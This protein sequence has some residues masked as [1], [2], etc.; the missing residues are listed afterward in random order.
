MQKILTTFKISISQITAERETVFI[1]SISSALSLISIIAVWLASDISTLGGY[2]RSELIT[3]YIVVF[4]LEQFIGWYV[5]WEIREEI[6]EG[7]IANYLLK[8][9]RYVT[10]I[11]V[12]QGAYKLLNLFT[13]IIVG[14][15]LFLALRQYI[16]IDLS[17]VLILKL[18]PAILI[19]IGIVFA[20]QFA[21]G[22]LT[23]FWTESY[24][25]SDIQWVTFLV[26]SG[27]ILPI[28]FYPKLLLT[29]VR[30]NPFRFTFSFPS[31]IIFHKVSG[32]E[33]VIGILIGIGWV[34]LLAILANFIWRKGLKKFAAYGS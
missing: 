34:I 7:T 14:S 1:W 29:Y 18:I 4:F 30:Y 23:F 12:H 16:H 32:P 26:F 27:Q 9:F 33:Y 15:I 17:F 8:P 2:T 31:E 13:H 22:C 24:F 6:M 3:Y 19:G 25:V 21:M 11:F 10:Y 5:F 28:S 20:T